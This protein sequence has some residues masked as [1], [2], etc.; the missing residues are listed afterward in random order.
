MFDKNKEIEV[1][2]FRSEEV[3]NSKRLVKFE[4][5]YENMIAY[6]I[7]LKKAVSTNISDLRMLMHNMLPIA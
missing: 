6:R 2:E 7:M 5:V 1:I 3:W 4:L